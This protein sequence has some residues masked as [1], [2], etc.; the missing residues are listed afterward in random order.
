MMTLDDAKAA[1]P[2]PVLWGRLGLPGNPPQE[3]GQLVSCPFPARHRHGDKKPSFNFHSSGGRFKCFGCNIEGGAV[4][5]LALA[6]GLYE[7]A[8]CRKLIELAGGAVV[9]VSLV[10]ASHPTPGVPNLRNRERLQISGLRRGNT[11]EWWRL[12]ETRALCHQALRWAADFGCLRFGEVCGFPSWV[13]L[14]GA[15]RTAEARRLNRQAFPAL[16]SLGERKAHSLKGTDKSWPVGVDV[17]RVHPSFR[18][19]LLVEGSPDF[20]A[21]LHFMYEHDICDVWP[22]A[23]LGRSTGGMIHREALEL[24]RGRKVRIYPHADADG[25]GVAAAKKWARQLAAVGCVVDAFSFGELRQ[26][27]GSPVK[28]LNDCCAIHPD[29]E[30]ILGGLL[31]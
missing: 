30:A 17:L 27:D 5:L 18:A 15:G 4:D 11:Y 19:V 28:D 24:L 8:A 31:P 2:L 7:K 9:P 21:A 13:L 23:M 25:G 6:L 20:L 1:L 3:D 29:D 22:V 14:D 10:Q 26:R 12:R 16:G